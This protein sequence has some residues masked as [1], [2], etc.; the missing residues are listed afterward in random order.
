MH[1]SCHDSCLDSLL[2]ADLHGRVSSSEP[3]NSVNPHSWVQL[4]EILGS[5]WIFLDSIN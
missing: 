4:V 3:C 2:Q 1:A 5:G